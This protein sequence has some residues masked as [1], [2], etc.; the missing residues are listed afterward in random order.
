MAVFAAVRLA[1]AALVAL[2]SRLSGHSAL[3]GLA[4]SWDSVWYLHIAT[5]GYG[6]RLH[7]TQSGAVQTDWA[8]FPLY[9]GLVH[10]VTALLP[11]SPAQAAVLLAWGAAGAAALGVHSLVHRL[12]GPSTAAALVVLWAVLPQSVVLS[13]A[14]T[15][16]LC[17]ALCAWCLYALFQRRWAA[18]GVLAG[19]AGL[20]RPNGI[21]AA[22]AVIVVAGREVVRRDGRVPAG[23]WAGVL[24]APLGWAGYVLWVGHRTGD[25][26]H[27]YF[28]VQNA[29]DTR[30]DLGAGTLRFLV[31]LPWH[32]GDVV[33]DV[34]LVI[35]VAAIALF[36]RL[37]R[38]R[39]PLALLVYAGVLLLPVVAVSGP[40]ESR[41][42]FLLPAFPL[43]VPAARALVRLRR[44]RPAR[45]R[46]VGA[47]LTV[48]SL[49]YGTYLAFASH[50]P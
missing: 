25:L 26:L 34:A 45:F 49:T 21:A 4:H 44:T 13:L 14:Y 28:H 23:L 22:A 31:S 33:H 3:K 24:V 48:V 39:A 19:F 16:P 29:W 12:Y 5:H 35:V 11:L 8:F 42:R 38:E 41:P 2:V 1:G 17:A 9:P 20:S 37:C 36:W 43:L 50:S 30:L 18:A 6:T 27:G 15:E 7:I 32:G 46:L 10:A 40:F 47:A